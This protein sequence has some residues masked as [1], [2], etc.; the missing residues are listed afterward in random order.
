MTALIM[1]LPHIPST[2]SQHLP[3]LFNIYGRMLFWDRERRAIE[4]QP[5]GDESEEEKQEV[6]LQREEGSWD[7]LSYILE[8]EDETVPELLHYYTF[9]YGLYPVNFMSYI[10]KPQRYLRHAKFPGA[11]DLDIEPTEIRQ[12]SEPF[13]QVHLLH[14]NFFMLTIESELTDNNR[15]MKSSSADV[16]A[17]CMAL[18]VPSDDGQGIFTRSRGPAKKSEVLNSDIPDQPLLE[19]DTATPFQSRHS[20]W[21]N[22]TSTMVASPDLKRTTSQT[23]QSLHS[24]A[25]SPPLR[26][27]DRSDSPTLPPMLPPIN[28]Q[29]ND[30][31]SSQRSMRSSLYQS[32]TNESVAS[33][34]LSNKQT[35]SVHVDS[36]LASLTRDTIPRSPSLR[37]TTYD[38]SLKVAYLQR[39][40]QLLRNDL[41]F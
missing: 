16:V 30:V 28:S 7:K 41:N 26:P 12:R 11:D 25:D 8:S 31:I 13:R 5:G 35:E 3:A 14:P 24:I 39:E 1:F 18:Y 6:V 34:A 37:P 9:L 2:A 38:R 40:I 33:L 17:E 29:L 36:Y 22:T 23:S 10:R 15:W 21:R 19:H 32:L 20:S 27:F 4:N